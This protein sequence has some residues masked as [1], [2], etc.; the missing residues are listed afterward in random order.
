M[1]DV[2]CFLLIFG[3]IA[4]FLYFDPVIDHASLPVSEEKRKVTS[5]YGD[6]ILLRLPQK[7]G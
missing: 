6:S 2:F 3:Q 1:S 5:I 4:A 7:S